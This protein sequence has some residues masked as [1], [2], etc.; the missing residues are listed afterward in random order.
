MFGHDTVWGQSVRRKVFQVEGNDHL[1]MCV[2]GG[3]KHVAILGIVREG[4]DESLV[5][6]DKGIVLGEESLNAHVQ[7]RGTLRSHPTV[8]DEVADHLIPNVTADLQPIQP[9]LQRSEQEIA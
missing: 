5:P 9:L 7:I 2:D 3:C 4:R 1:C 8:L 6:A